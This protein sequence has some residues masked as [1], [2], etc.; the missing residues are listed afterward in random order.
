MGGRVFIRVKKY[1]Y[2][3]FWRFGVVADFFS[4]QPALKKYSLFLF[5]VNREEGGVAA[6]HDTGNFSLLC[7]INFSVLLYFERQHRALAEGFEKK[8]LREILKVGK[9]RIPVVF[10]HKQKILFKLILGVGNSTE[11]K[12]EWNYQWIKKF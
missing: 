11:V 9:K 4:G 5:A 2:C 3:L 12:I 1:Y 7:K 10:I 8:S 6:T